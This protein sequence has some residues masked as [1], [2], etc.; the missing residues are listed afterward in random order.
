MGSLSR[1][2]GK[3]STDFGSGSSS[4]PVST[5]SSACTGV[6][7]CSDSVK[8]ARTGSVGSRGGDGGSGILIG[9]TSSRSGGSGDSTCLSSTAS[10]A[11][12]ARSLSSRLNLRRPVEFMTGSSSREGDCVGG[13]GTFEEALCDTIDLR[14]LD[15]AD[16]ASWDVAERAIERRGE[17][18]AL[19]GTS[20]DERGV[21]EEPF[22][23]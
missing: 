1:A 3:S 2:R 12:D 6:R 15:S 17:P 11:R 8:G 4:G 19:E 10:F 13:E 16:S 23:D 20:I 14:R 5:I 21:L 18:S 22:S 7:C 9:S